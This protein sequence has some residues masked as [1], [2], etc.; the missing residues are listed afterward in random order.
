MPSRAGLAPAPPPDYA[1]AMRLESA[2][3]TDRGLRRP[4]NEDAFLVMEEARVFAVAD[5]MG[6]HAA[7]EVA[8]RTAIETV[9]RGAGALGGAEADEARLTE[10]VRTANRL[11]RARAAADPETAGM[12]TTLTLLAV[13]PGGGT[14]H[15]AHIGDSR[16]YRLRAGS[17]RQLTTDHTWAQAQID[18]GLLAP[19]QAAGHPF[20]SVL[21]RA[22]GTAND[23]EVDTLEGELRPGD[24]LLL[25]SDGLSGM[26]EDADV[27]AI[28]S[29]ALPLSTMAEHL[30][31]AAN[32]RG[33]LDNVTVVLV[34]AVE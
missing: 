34:R 29:Q 28:L 4:G 25:S 15:V 30:V 16:A 1:C 2:A 23:V 33:G 27:E 26:V 11:I 3:R 32:L 31:E 9:E 24:L 19:E 14:F 8:S 13:A 21:T 7:G 12:G 17:L 5:G 10:W 22:L 6:G 20:A 18:A